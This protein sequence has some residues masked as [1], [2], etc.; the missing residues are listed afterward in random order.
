MKEN[1]INDLPDFTR[2]EEVVHAWTHGIGAIVS[3]VAGYL[4]IQKAMGFGQN[5]ML[6]GI[7]IFSFTLFFALFASTIYHGVKEVRLKR[8]LRIVDHLAIYLLIAGTFTPYTLVNLWG[9][10]G[11]TILVFIWGVAFLGMAFKILIRNNLQQYEKYDVVFYVVMGCSAFFFF[12]PITTHIE[13][14]GIWFLVLGGASYLVGVY[15]YLNK[16]IP[17]HHAIW[18]IFVMMGA[19]FH[20]VSIYYYV[21]PKIIG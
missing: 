9:N 6:V 7:G 2:H 18:H 20:Y 15:F 13:S 3:I 17:Y 5:R 1:E 8:I 19:G 12:N 10:W 21:Y 4:I 14:N 16:K 11:Q